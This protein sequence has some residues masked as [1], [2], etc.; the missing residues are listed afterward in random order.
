M[1]C[2]LAKHFVKDY[3][4]V[5]DFKVRQRY[6]VISGITGIFLNVLLCAAKLSAG[7][8]SSSISIIGDAVNNLSDAAS[9]VV[10][11]VGFKLAGQ[12]ADEEHPFGH[13]RFEY[14][15]GLIV[16]LLIVV[17]GVELVQSS[18]H[19]IIH[20]EKT[21]FNV[22]TAAVL[23]FSIIIKAFMFSSNLRASNKI[24]S[25]TLRSTAMDSISDVLTTS[26]VL[27]CS[28]INY[29]KQ[30]NLDGYAGLL[31]A[32]LIIKTGIDSAKDT[33]NPLLGEPPDKGF[34]E[35]I[36]AIALS[37]KD[38]MGVHDI[39][40]HNYGP[41]RIFMSLHVEVP[42]NLDI[43]TVHDSI[44]DIENILRKKYHCTAVIHV[45][46]IVTND[47]MTENI[48]KKVNHFLSE[49]GEELTFHDLRFSHARENNPKLSFDVIVP[50]KYDL[51]DEEIVSFLE[52]HLK[53]LIPGV[54]IEIEI[55]K[56]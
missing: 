19:K 29:Y 27:I 23:I 24:N 46:P 28:F 9:S 5:G 17:T 7:V 1:I 39:I 11:L 12:E 8:I 30:L 41:S 31:V 37:S 44:D 50:Y 21:L 14:I 18:F 25:A 56:G 3:D 51:P 16:S 34:L 38:V 45:D 43:V 33:I 35:D 48:K 10:T 6:G 47:E 40:V 49:L 53:P 26:I 55:D 36:K 15:S 2:F 54:E 4:Q 32:V 13:G 52:N 22:F 42:S 20:P